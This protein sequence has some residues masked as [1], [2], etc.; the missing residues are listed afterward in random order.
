[1]SDPSNPPSRAGKIIGIVIALG[2]SILVLGLFFSLVGGG[3]L[4]LAAAIIAL[5][6]AFPLT[7]SA[8]I[9]VFLVLW[10]RRA[11]T[12]RKRD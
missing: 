6:L 12:R 2:L 3:L 4:A 5:P 9:G 8:V 7:L 1:V 11:F 10:L